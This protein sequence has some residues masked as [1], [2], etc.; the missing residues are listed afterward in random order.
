MKQ[1]KEKEKKNMNLQLTR[2]NDWQKILDLQFK[3]FLQKFT[4]TKR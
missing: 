1:K 3:K 4:I 2:K